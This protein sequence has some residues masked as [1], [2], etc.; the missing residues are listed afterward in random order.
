KMMFGRRFLGGPENRR[1][2]KRWLWAADRLG[3][4]RA[5]REVVSRG[6]VAD[7]LGKIGCPVLVLRGEEGQVRTRQES[8]RIVAGIRG[9]RLAEV[10]GAGHMAPVERPE[11]VAR[12]IR[13]FVRDAEG[14]G[15][16]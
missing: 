8:E 3:V 11:E 7:Q 2:A 1:R 5:A 15:C 12:E 13:R 16:S 9:S 14:P 10:P 4:C 6:Q